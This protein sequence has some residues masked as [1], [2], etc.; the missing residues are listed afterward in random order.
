M[1]AASTRQTLDLPENDYAIG[2]GFET[3]TS[4]TPNTI[5]SSHVQFHCERIPNR[6]A[7]S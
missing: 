1:R 5:L 7:L 4:Q 6:N 3:Q 2:L